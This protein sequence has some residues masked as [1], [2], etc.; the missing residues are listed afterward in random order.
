VSKEINKKDILIQRKTNIT[1]DENKLSHFDDVIE[2]A[3]RLT[4][5]SINQ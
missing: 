4:N 1:K 5:P 2:V 3:N